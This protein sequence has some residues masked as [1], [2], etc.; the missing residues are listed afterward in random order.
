[1]TYLEDEKNSTDGI[2]TCSIGIETLDLTPK[3]TIPSFVYQPLDRSRDSL[4]LLILL[5]CEE[6]NESIIRCGL[7]HS[8]F[9]EIPI[10]EALSYMW[11][12][13]DQMQSILVDGTLVLV[14]QNLYDALSSL[15]SKEPR[16]LWADALCINQENL[17]ERRCQVALMDF[18]YEQASCVL[19]WLGKWCKALYEDEPEASESVKNEEAAGA[20]RD[21]SPDEE[22]AS[23]FCSWIYNNPYWERLWIIQEMA[24]ARKLR[25]QIGSYRMDW[26]RLLCFVTALGSHEE[27]RQRE[28]L[29]R[30]ND[31]RIARHSPLTRLEV[32]LEDFKY[33]K[34]DEPRDKIYGFLGLASDCQRVPSLQ[35]DYSKPLTDLHSEVIAMFNQPRL[36]NDGQDD[37]M[38]RSMRIVRYSRL[39]W[40][41]ICGSQINTIYDDRECTPETLSDSL[42]PSMM[43]QTRAFILCKIK[44]LGP[45]RTEIISSSKANKDWKFAFEAHYSNPEN[46]HSLRKGHEIYGALLRR[47][48]KNEVARYAWSGT[49]LFQS[50]GY[51][52]SKL[53]NPNS[54]QWLVEENSIVESVEDSNIKVRWNGYEI[55]VPEESN[56]E[57]PEGSN[58]RLL[59]D[60]NLEIHKKSNV[61]SPDDAT[62]QNFSNIPNEEEIGRVKRPPPSSEAR[63]YLGDQ[64]V[65][66]LVPD[67][68][69]VGDLICQFWDTDV[70]ALLRPVS[71]SRF[72]QV[73]GRAHIFDAKNLVNPEVKV[74]KNGTKR[75][76][77]GKK[78][79]V[80]EV[81]CVVI[82]M[83]IR[84]LQSLS[85]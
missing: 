70:A 52:S 56:F 76:K 65:I 80:K 6:R 4:R 10:Y 16:Y 2:P 40:T 44:H 60:S 51:S 43:I 66:G 67:L 1:M 45:T 42:S 35:A 29:I 12:A 39:V 36:P 49:D 15:R 13:S 61:L 8:N 20:T 53:W 26:D 82:N 50:Y 3:S 58:I 75:L 27:L 23:E 25:V 5:P 69:E 83:D 32:L 14:R 54:S 79:V 68:A 37:R 24:L 77:K 48:S 63:L 18:I 57:R 84:T 85:C 55:G 38:D 47:M 7:I 71:D 78:S 28:G 41:S 81:N 31:L 59:E 64:V 72:Y 46:I 11:G 62:S 74:S 19:I 22:D 21:W 33:A 73:V 34:C 9:A 30:L 17:D